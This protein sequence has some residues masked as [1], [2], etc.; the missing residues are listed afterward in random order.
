MEFAKKAWRESESRRKKG[1]THERFPKKE[2]LF[3]DLEDRLGLLDSV[4]DGLDLLDLGVARSG[5]LRLS[6]HLQPVGARSEVRPASHEPLR[7]T[8]LMAKGRRTGTPSGG[9]DR[10]WIISF[11]FAQ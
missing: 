2:S 6:P 11:F 3:F 4:E 8:M 5:L 10:T 9:R 1:S 7:K